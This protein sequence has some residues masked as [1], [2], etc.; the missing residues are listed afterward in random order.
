MNGRQGKSAILLGNGAVKKIEN[1]FIPWQCFSITI[2]S[3]GL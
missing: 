2:T 1:I 3:M